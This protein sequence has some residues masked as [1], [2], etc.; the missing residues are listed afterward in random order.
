[1]EGLLIS[2]LADALTDVGETERS[3]GHGDGEDRASTRLIR[4]SIVVHFSK[5]V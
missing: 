1:M 3:V 2:K 5:C 4:M